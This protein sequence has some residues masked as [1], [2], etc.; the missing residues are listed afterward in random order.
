[1]DYISSRKLV[2]VPQYAKLIENSEALGYWRTQ[3]QMGQNII[4]Y[5]FDGPRLEDG[6]VTSELCSLQLLRTKINDTRHPFGHGYV[7]AAL[8]M[9]IDVRH[10][11]DSDP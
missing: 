7:V 6:D 9:G 2:Y 10:F 8:L 11:T 3:L 1:M 5:D 4:V